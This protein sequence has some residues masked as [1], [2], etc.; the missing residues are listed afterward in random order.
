MA[1]AIMRFEK[2]KAAS[3]GSLAGSLAHTFR[4]RFTPNANPE[5]IVNNETLVGVSDPEEVIE[6]IRERYPEK[7]RTNNVGCYE[8]LVAYSPGADI[9]PG[10]YFDLSINWLE[11]EFGAGNVV[12][13]VRHNDETT[14]HIAAYVVP[15]DPKTGNLNARRWTG[16]RDKCSSLQTRFWEYAG[17]DLGLERGVK[18]SQASHMTIKAWY[19]ENLSLDQKRQS[20]EAEREKLE[21]REK[22]LECRERSIQIGK[23]DITD[24]ELELAKKAE[25]MAKS[26]TENHQRIDRENRSAQ[27][28]MARAEKAERRVYHAKKQLDNQGKLLDQR[29]EELDKRDIDIEEKHAKVLGREQKI[30]EKETKLENMEIELKARGDKLQ[31]KRDALDERLAVAKQQEDRWLAAKTEWE[32]A[33]RP[34]QVPTIVQHL[35]RLQKMGVVESA[36]YIEEVC[37]DRLY[38]LFSAIDGLTA[39]GKKLLEEHAGR[40]AELQRWEQTFLSQLSLPEDRGL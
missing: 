28:R 9:N 12:S 26:Y 37:D 22:D 13:V 24:R 7:I 30:E 4:S 40:S 16:G 6:A 8:F 11:K 10:V 3:I 23:D 38:D 18:G 35:Q 34:A 21:Q 14:P 31:S 25:K 15:L 20:I 5:R 17:R 29:Q 19:G 33:N 2:H 39:Q 32:T 27:I 1:Y 36:E